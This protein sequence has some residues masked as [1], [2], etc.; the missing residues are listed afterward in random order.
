[1]NDDLT[2]WEP[3]SGCLLWTGRT[4]KEY[5]VVS[6][7]NTSFYAHRLAYEQAY[8][9]I[10]DGLCVL[11]K[12][13]TPPCVNPAHLFLGTKRD[14]NRDKIQKGR[15]WTPKGIAHGCAKLTEDDVR[16]IREMVLSGM[17]HREVAHCFG[18]TR[19]NVG[20]IAQRKTWKTVS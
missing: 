20:Y 15:Q 2:C 14:N 4:V 16:K 10:P 3:N 1:M 17:T 6:I 9:P 19:K 7:G 8:G 5:G 11:H 18:I 13:D 12:C